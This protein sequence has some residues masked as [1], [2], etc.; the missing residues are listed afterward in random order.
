VKHEGQDEERK[1]TDGHEMIAHVAVSSGAWP[2]FNAEDAEEQEEKPV[3]EMNLS[4]YSDAYDRASER[5]E[6]AR[7]KFSEGRSR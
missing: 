3:E 1:F 5:V 7:R 2:D 6:R 4:E